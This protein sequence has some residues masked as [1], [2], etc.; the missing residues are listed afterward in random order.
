MIGLSTYI[1]GSHALLDILPYSDVVREF[2]LSDGHFASVRAVEHA[3][4]MA[5]AAEESLV[6][7]DFPALDRSGVDEETPDVSYE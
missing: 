3:S 4:E 5:G 6:P 1:P 7:L 2:L